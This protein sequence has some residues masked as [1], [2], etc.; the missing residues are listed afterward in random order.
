MKVQIVTNNKGEGDYFYI[1]LDNKQIESG[2]SLSMYHWSE[3]LKRIQGY[4]EV[5][6][7]DLTDEEFEAWQLELENSF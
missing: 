2:H 4:R 5:E 3:V 7:K 6:Y 1:F